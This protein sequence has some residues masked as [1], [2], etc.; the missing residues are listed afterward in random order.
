VSRSKRNLPLPGMEANVREWARAFV[1]RTYPDLT[2]RYDREKMIREA[3]A[4]CPVRFWL[5]VQANL[6]ARWFRT[7]FIE[8]IKGLGWALPDGSEGDALIYPME[9]VQNGR[10]AIDEAQAGWLSKL[11]GAGADLVTVRQEIE[12]Y[13]ERWNGYVV[14]SSGEVIDID[15]QATF[16]DLCAR[17]SLPQIA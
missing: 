17:A 6:Y 15:A 4:A 8:A 7:E 16:F 13:A 10:P 5:K 3:Q 2:E 12:E 14:P 11:R 1:I 9:R